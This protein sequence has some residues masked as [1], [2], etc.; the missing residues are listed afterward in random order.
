MPWSWRYSMVRSTW[1][2]KWM[3][4]ICYSFPL[5][6]KFK[7]YPPGTYYI[8]MYK[9]LGS[10]VNP[11]MLAYVERTDTINGCER[12]LRIWN[13]FW[14]CYACLS[15]MICAFLIILMAKYFELSLCLTSLTRLNVPM[16]QSMYLCLRY[17]RL[18]SQ[19]FWFSSYNY[20]L[21]YLI[22]IFICYH[23]YSTTLWKIHTLS[24]SPW[25]TR[26]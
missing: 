23:P 11:S 26:C 25:S 19:Q 21:T 5:W 2:A 3:H 24:Q 1:L 10:C 15:L 16:F 18:R 8:T 7:S 14:T 9:C 12:V 6:I 22:T 17:R 13:S 20:Y 4:C